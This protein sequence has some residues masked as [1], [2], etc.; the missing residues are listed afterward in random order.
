MR[1]IA[2]R[3]TQLTDVVDQRA[4]SHVHALRDPAQ[5]IEFHSPHPSVEKVVAV[6]AACA[7]LADA[8]RDTVMA[9]RTMLQQAVPTTFGLKGAGWLVGVVEAR[10]RLAA[11]ELAAQL[12]GAAGTLGVLGEKGLEVLRLFAEELDLAEPV[13]P[14]HA[15]RARLVE[16][17]R[18]EDEA[19]ALA[20]DTTY[21]LAGAVWTVDAGRAQRVAGRLRHGTIWINDYNVYMPQAEWGGFRQ[22]GQGRELG[23]TG[24]DEYREAKHVWENTAPGV[25]GWFEG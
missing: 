10:R 25:S 18:T 21:G 6:A 24:L 9:A 2:T 17:F 5:E 14:W 23:P 11:V 16:R 22:S 20:N 1:E 8:H 3:V 12:G 4:L 13:L 7:R 19:V 15:N